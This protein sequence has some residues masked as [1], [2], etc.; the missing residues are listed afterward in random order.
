M[1][2]RHILILSIMVVFSLI[3]V[4]CNVKDQTG[5]ENIRQE[6]NGLKADALQQEILLENIKISIKD[7][8]AL[9]AQNDELKREILRLDELINLNESHGDLTQLTLHEQEKYE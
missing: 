7:I 5:L 1:Q 9:K 3:V 2:S 6:I 4:G 8:E